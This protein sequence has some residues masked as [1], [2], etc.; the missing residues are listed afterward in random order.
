MSEKCKCEENNRTLAS[1]NVD[2][3]CF[4]LD[5]RL[6][7]V[8]VEILKCPICGKISIGWYPQEDTEDITDDRDF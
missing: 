4:E 3:C 1:S 7:N 8:T 5:K 6:K 2:P